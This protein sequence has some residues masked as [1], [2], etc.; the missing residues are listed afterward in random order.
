MKLSNNTQRNMTIH[1]LG[2]IYYQTK[3]LVSGM[4]YIFL[5]LLAYRVP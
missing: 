5:E 1:Q 3:L 4:G 2:T